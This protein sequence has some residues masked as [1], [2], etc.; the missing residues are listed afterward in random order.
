MSSQQ[1]EQ[2]RQNLKSTHTKSNSCE[3]TKKKQSQYLTAIQI[4]KSFPR[5][6]NIIIP[7]SIAASCYQISL[8][9]LAETHK[10]FPVCIATNLD[11]T[12]KDLVECNV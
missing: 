11:Q 7:K 12:K 3:K 6:K 8:N 9:I 1:Q 5:V 4:A 10:P 2:Q